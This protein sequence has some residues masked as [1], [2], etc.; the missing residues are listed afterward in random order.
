MILIGNTVISYYMVYIIVHLMYSKEDKPLFFMIF[1]YLFIYWSCFL[2]F[3][4]DF[5]R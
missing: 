1:F 3:L 2:L 4:F 5:F